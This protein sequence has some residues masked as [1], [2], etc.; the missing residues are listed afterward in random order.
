LCILLYFPVTLNKNSLGSNFSYLDINNSA[1]NNVSCT[2]FKSLYVSTLSYGDCSVIL[3]KDDCS[4]IIV[5]FINF[6]YVDYCNIQ[7]GRD[8]Y[9]Q[10]K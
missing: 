3:V 2:F 1:C 7:L 6:V 10:N 9:K 5:W 4:N 8:I